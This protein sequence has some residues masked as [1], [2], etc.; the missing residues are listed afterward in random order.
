[1]AYKS[2]PAEEHAYKKIDKEIR[3]NSI[4]NLLL[5]YGKEDY[6]IR[7]AIN[8][9]IGKYVNEA[10]RDMDF[11]KIDGTAVTFEQIRDCC[12]TL[13]FLSE[14][15]VVHLS[16]L[17]LIE[18]GKTKGLD[19]DGEK[20]LAEYLKNLPEQCMLIITSESADKRKKL[21]KSISEC[22]SAYEFGEL[23]EKSL[24]SYIEKRFKES[25]K[26]ARPAVIE[27]LIAASGY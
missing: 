25:G 24:K 13:P 16:D 17:K 5:L 23:D 22:G 9:L 26:N 2:S 15:R 11:S 6:L 12:E 18:G 20:L 10:C 14:K 3:N 27:G 4:K 21:Y 8:T 19:E 1:M 7:W